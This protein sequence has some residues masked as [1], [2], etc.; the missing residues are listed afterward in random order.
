MYVAFLDVADDDTH[1]VNGFCSPVTRDELDRLD[2]RER[3]Y[4]RVEIGARLAAPP[5]RTWAYLGSE[6]GRARM[7][8]GRKTARLV[9]ARPYLSAVEDAFAR[10]G[11]REL[12]RFKAS[13]DPPP[14]PVLEL[15]RVDV[16]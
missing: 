3:N 10:L 7:R 12:E 5:G 14:G 9:V 13:S 11:G 2:A 4:R 6:A 1:E 16:S 15:Q 8:Q